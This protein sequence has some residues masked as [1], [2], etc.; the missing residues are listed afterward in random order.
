MKAGQFI[1]QFLWYLQK[2]L[3]ISGREN[4]VLSDKITRVPLKLATVSRLHSCL[5][6][7]GATSCYLV[8][9]EWRVAYFRRN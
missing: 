6:I 9:P 8:V 4:T 5:K 3:D 1:H 7:S 2:D